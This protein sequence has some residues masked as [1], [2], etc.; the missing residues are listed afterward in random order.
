MWAQKFLFSSEDI[1]VIKHERCVA[2]KRFEM[3]KRKENQMKKLKRSDCQNKKSH[4]VV[5]QKIIFPGLEIY[6]WKEV[7]ALCRQLPK[8][9]KRSVDQKFSR[10]SAM[11]T[12]V[13][14]R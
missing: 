13:I 14:A 5:E 3:S 4:Q 8:P 7:C 9:E 1:Q 11:S 12:C 2:N 10:N 6:E